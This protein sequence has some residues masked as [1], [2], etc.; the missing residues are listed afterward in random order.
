[1]PLGWN[2][3]GFCYCFFSFLFALPEKTLLRLSRLPLFLHALFS[4]SDLVDDQKVT[5]RDC[6]RLTSPPP[7]YLAKQRSGRIVCET[8]RLEKKMV[9]EERVASLLT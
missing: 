1:M 2:C 3:T 5:R 6:R 7:F 8:V 9:M 4:L